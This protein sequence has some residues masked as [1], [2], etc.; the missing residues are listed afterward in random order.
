MSVGGHSI[1]GLT[2]DPGILAFSRK[3][4]ICKEVCMKLV[5]KMIAFMMVIAAVAFV[6]GFAPE[7]SEAASAKPKINVSSK[8][9]YVGGS[10]VR[11]SYGE[12]YTFY[13]K[14]RPK[15]YSVT[16]SSSDESVAKI[17]KLKYSKAQVT[18][19]AAGK[20]TITADFIDK[21]TSTKYTLTTVVTVKKNAAAVSISPQTIPKIDKGE[22]ISLSATLYNKDASEAKTGEITDTVK[23]LSS[24]PNV[25]TVNSSGLVT[26]VKAGKTTITCYTVQK[27]SGAYSKFE[28]ATAKKSVEIEVNDPAVIGI[29]S[30]TQTTLTDI[31]V[32]FGGD[33]S[34]NVTKDNLAVKKDGIQIPVKDIKFADNKLEAT[35]SMYSSLIDATTYT[36][37]YNNSLLTEGQTGTFVASVGEPVRMELYTDINR[38][39]VVA[40]KLTPIRFRLFNS[41]NVDITP[42]D[43]SSSEYYNAGAKL[44]LKQA[45]S[46]QLYTSWYIDNGSKS[47][48]V[49]EEGKTVTVSGDYI[50]LASTGTG[51]SDKTLTATIVLTSVSE[52]STMVFSG[53]TIASGSKSGDQLNWTEPVLRISVSDTTGYKIVARI[54][55]SDGKYVY[56]NSD[57]S[58]LVFS[59][60][61]SSA[62]FVKDDG[63]IVPFS[64]GNDSVNI[65]Y[66][67]DITHGVPIGT[68]TVNVV[69]KRVPTR[70]V[71]EQNGSPVSTITMS[72]SYG[73]SDDSVNIRVYDQYNDLIDITN[74]AVSSSIPL[75]TVLIA[76]VNEYGPTANGYANTDG[77]GRIEFNAV[78][79]GTTSGRNYQMKVSYNDAAYGTLDGYITLIV[80]TPDQTA[81]SS[82]RVEVEGDKNMKVS[83]G[84]SELPRL[85][86][87]LYEIK[88]NVK[89]NR[90]LT[91]KPS[92]NITGTYVADGDF[93]YRLYKNDTTAA[94]VR[95]GIVTDYINVVYEAN[96]GLVK[97]EPGSYS[98]RVYKRTGSNDVLVA[99]KDIVLTD[100]ASI[101]CDQISATTS[102]PLKNNMTKDELKIVFGECF[103]VMIGTDSVGTSQIDFGD[104]TITNN[105]QVFFRSVTVTETVT[106]GGRVYTLTHKVQL[107]TTIRNK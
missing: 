92:P 76:C 25:A 2:S 99:T 67:T 69:G 5:K 53:A 83:S 96:N 63:T 100:T 60:V 29:V 73:V 9:I 24:D 79:I 13:I 38:D 42:T 105:G 49:M 72:D 64:T 41:N 18:A 77:S 91:V 65:Y 88:R 62:C 15:K 90:I 51:Y 104:D 74:N 14:N 84:V 101:K 106:I 22:T 81:P 95:Y 19:V 68:I 35:V 86:I 3:E 27:T 39:K 57:S 75:S 48:Y 1:F 7:K 52:A 102:V 89:F 44:T 97:Y 32:V 20:A 12:T 43:T 61:T 103:R 16:W 80:F 98:L 59:S 55:T 17:E 6:I 70:M 28:K 94:E 56:S 93:F 47:V 82:Y 4:G 78:G 107:N 85:E 40:G 33:Y 26:A 8:V 45:D 11:P 34:T 58:N 21:V 31:K 71:F 46:S 37:T 36:V 87:K 23:W 10:S 30:V 66:G 54:K 50:Y